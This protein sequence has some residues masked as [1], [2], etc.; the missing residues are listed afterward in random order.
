MK[1]NIIKTGVEVD[2]NED[3]FLIDNNVLYECHLTGTVV[4]P[5]G[6][7][8]IASTAFSGKCGIIKVVL[9]EGLK[10]IRANAFLGCAE[11]KEIVIPESVEIIED[12]A[13]FGC[14]MLKKVHLPKNL[15]NLGIKAFTDSGLESVD[16][17]KNPDLRISAYAFSNTKL[18][19][20]TIPAN[21]PL[22]VAMFKECKKL[23]TVIF[24]GTG[25]KVPEMCFQLCENLKNIDIR[26]IKTVGRGGFL[27]CKSLDFDV[28]PKDIRVKDGAFSGCGIKRITV[29]DL[30]SIEGSNEV[31]YGCHQLTKAVIEV[32]GANIPQ[33]T[34]EIPPALFSH[35]TSLEK[36][37]FTGMTGKITSI[38]YDAFELTALKEFEVPENVTKIDNMTFFKAMQ[39]TEITLPKKLRII[40]RQAFSESGLKSI[41]LPDSVKCVETECFRDCRYLEEAT[42]PEKDFVVPEGMFMNCITLKNLNNADRIVQIGKYAFY[43]AINLKQIDLSSVTEIGGNAFESSGLASVKL[44]KCCKTLGPNAFYKCKNLKLA[45]L[46]ECSI[47][48]FAPYVF[49]RCG[50]SQHIAEIILP[51]KIWNVD[52]CAF[53]EC[54]IKNMTVAAAS[55]KNVMISENAFT[56]SNI[57]VLTFADNPDSHVYLNESSFKDAFIGELTIPDY[58]YNKYKNVWDNVRSAWDDI[59]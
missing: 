49:Y 25:I 38:G 21:L 28:L 13:F 5:D 44:P 29:E 58:L 23:E 22:K 45:D 47:E 57:D 50:G 11:L 43:D 33:D 36:V 30:N 48:Y 1:L 7:T 39:L 32:R 54:Y 8:E 15:K 4:V 19:Q 40:G 20:V 10:I 9:P 16:L 12:Q 31:F 14:K 42:L 46:S 34:K 56:E 3:A 17:P 37:S 27:G 18:H 2:N 51:D 53:V 55:G 6:V 52:E 59:E 24:E 35:C 41:T 26:A